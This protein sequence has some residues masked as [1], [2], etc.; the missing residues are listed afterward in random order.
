M[1]PEIYFNPVSDMRMARHFAARWLAPQTPP[2]RRARGA[3]DRDGPRRGLCVDL[4]EVSHGDGL[5]GNSHST[6]VSP[7]PPSRN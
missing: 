2:V 3:L 6:T 7:K 1:R 4:I 5:N